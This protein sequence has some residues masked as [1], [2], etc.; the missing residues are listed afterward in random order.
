ML[1]EIRKWLL[2]AQLRGPT[3]GPAARALAKSGD[4]SLIPTLL[5]RLRSEDRNG[6]WL[7]LEML[8]QLGDP[9]TPRAILGQFRPR[10]D[11]YPALLET[12]ERLGASGDESF[13]LLGAIAEDTSYRQRLRDGSC[14]FDHTSECHR[15]KAIERFGRFGARS[16]PILEQLAGNRIRPETGDGSSEV[17]AAARAALALI[18]EWQPATPTRGTYSDEEIQFVIDTLS[19]WSIATPENYSPS[20]WD[21]SR[22]FRPKL[23][24]ADV[25]AKLCQ[26]GLAKAI[27]EATM[28]RWLEYIADHPDAARAKGFVFQPY[29][30][31]EAGALVRE[32]EA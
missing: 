9:T 32:R 3:P 20:L 1:S 7:V 13:E 21:Y 12:F 10:A 28:C 16:I 29:L 23:A 4:K 17:R 15:L 8:G 14:R 30:Q 18:P 19:A 5:K 26:A 22:I 6:L 25:R 11:L 27:E 2:L 31:G 24:V